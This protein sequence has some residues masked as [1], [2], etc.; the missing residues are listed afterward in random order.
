MTYTEVAT[1]I[2]S[3]GLPYAYYQ[4]RETGVHPPFICFFY[5]GSNDFI[6]D[7]TNYQK[8]E[9]LYIELYADQ[10]DFD[11]EAAIE[12]VLAENG[13]VW[14]RE[15]QWIDSEKLYEVIYTM[16]VVITPDTEVSTNG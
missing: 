16:D 4:F 15:E 12:E 1:M 8:I 6:A 5:G 2:S 14:A 13:F 7:S 3:I 9:Q 11:H 10:K